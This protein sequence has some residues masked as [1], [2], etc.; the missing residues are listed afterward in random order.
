MK[1]PEL[2]FIILKGFRDPDIESEQK[3]LLDEL[4]WELAE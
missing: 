2:Y 1:C 3:E 4:R